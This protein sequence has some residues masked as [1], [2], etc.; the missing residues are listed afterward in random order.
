MSQRRKATLVVLAPGLALT[1]LAFVA[2]FLREATHA[3]ALEAIASPFIIAGWLM[4]I[5]Q[6]NYV[7]PPDED[8]RIA[9][10]ISTQNQEG[11]TQDAAN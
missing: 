5:V 11:E 7:I 6:L 9:A 8:P 2:L 4:S 10:R 1:V 3:I